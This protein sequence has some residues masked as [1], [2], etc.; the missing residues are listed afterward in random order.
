MSDRLIR[1][2]VPSSRTT[3]KIGT[4]NRAKRIDATRKRPSTGTLKMIRRMPT[5]I[6]PQ[7]PTATPMPLSRPRVSGQLTVLS[8][9]S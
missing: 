6:V 8:V 9:A 2:T 1:P 7:Y 5:K 4:A 3:T